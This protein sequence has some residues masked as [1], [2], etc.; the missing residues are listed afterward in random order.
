ML[1]VEKFNPWKESMYK[2]IK[3][4][5]APG[6]KG[7]ELG[8]SCHLRLSLSILYN[9]QRLPPR[10]RAPG[11]GQHQTHQ[12]PESTTDPKPKTRPG[13]RFQ[14][15]KVLQELVR[16]RTRADPQRPPPPS[17]GI[18]SYKRWSCLQSLRHTEWPWRD[19]R[20][21]LRIYQPNK[22]K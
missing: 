11:P 12:S 22:H 13:I 15:S 10:S 3:I 18:L 1:S 17:P 21:A 4:A 16:S 5:H 20:N 9:L 14:V 6:K 8:L 2:W 19:R 7:H